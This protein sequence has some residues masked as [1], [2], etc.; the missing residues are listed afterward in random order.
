MTV[1]LFLVGQ[2]P[3]IQPNLIQSSQA[4][5]QIIGFF[6]YTQLLLSWKWIRIYSRIIIFFKCIFSHQDKVIYALCCVFLLRGCSLSEVDGVLSERE[7]LS[8]EITQLV[9]EERKLDELIQSCTHEVKRMTESS[10][11]QKY[12]Y[13]AQKQRPVS[14]SVFVAVVCCDECEF[15]FL[16]SSLTTLTF[17]YVTYQD[18]RRDRKLRDQTVIVVKAPSETKLEVPDP[19]EVRCWLC[20]LLMVKQNVVKH[21]TVLRGHAIMFRIH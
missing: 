4:N 13:S 19:Q 7:T 9:E 16:Y 1:S 10:H 15:M 3:I 17:A 14:L 12:P 8:S 20:L 2:E 6:F 5:G 11:N 18:L 21:S